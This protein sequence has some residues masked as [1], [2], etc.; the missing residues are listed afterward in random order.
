MHN[1]DISRNAVEAKYQKHSINDP[2]PDN[3]YLNSADSGSILIFENDGAVETRDYGSGR[4]ERGSLRSQS[5]DLAPPAGSRRIAASL[6]RIKFGAMATAERAYVAH[7]F[8]R[9]NAPRGRN[10]GGDER[11]RTRIDD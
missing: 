9:A 6:P 4:T 5:G 1:N 2:H 11:S 10:A 8:G 7:A 3:W